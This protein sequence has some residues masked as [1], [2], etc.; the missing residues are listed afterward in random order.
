MLKQR[1]F[2]SFLLLPCFLFGPSS[3][4]HAA[5]KAVIR[6][7]SISGA[8]VAPA[9]VDPCEGVAVGDPCS[10]GVLYAGTGFATLGS[11][12]KYMTTPGNCSDFAN[13]FTEFTPTCNGATDTL[14]NKGYANGSGAS[15]YHTTTGMASFVTGA[16]NTMSLATMYTDTDAARYCHNMVYPAGGYSDWYLPARDELNLVLYGMHLAGKGSFSTANWYWSSSE[17]AA[18]NGWAKI[19]TDGSYY[20]CEKPNNHIVRCVRRYLVSGGFIR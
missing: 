17:Q 14:G 9:V 16:S 11:D 15:A 2:L 5:P 6:G 18:N 20:N 4:L 1:L 19:F 13:N 7:A 10:N 8:R 12:Y 3:P